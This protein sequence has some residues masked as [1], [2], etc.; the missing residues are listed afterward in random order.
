MT[1]FPKT[2]LHDHVVRDVQGVPLGRA[3]LLMDDSYR[4]GESL[5]VAL[6]TVSVAKAKKVQSLVFYLD[7]L[8]YRVSPDTPALR[9][10]QHGAVHRVNNFVLEPVAHG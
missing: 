9:I 8:P 6:L 5:R 4:E 3:I 7:G 1:E 2:L 10:R